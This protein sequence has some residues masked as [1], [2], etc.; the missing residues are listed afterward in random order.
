ML[1]VSD[2]LFAL[3]GFGFGVGCTI[4]VGQLLG[5][6][7]PAQAK[8]AGHSH[9]LP[10]SFLCRLA[11]KAFITT[12]LSVQQ[13][14]TGLS[15]NTQPSVS[16]DLH[17]NFLISPLHPL[18]Y[19]L[20]ADS[21]R[22][23]PPPPSCHLSAP[24]RNM[25]VVQHILFVKDEHSA[26]S[27]FL[28]LVCV[29]YFLSHSSALTYDCVAAATVTVAMGVTAAGIVGLNMFLLSDKLCQAFTRD[30]QVVQ[31]TLLPVQTDFSLA[32]LPSQASA[33]MTF[34]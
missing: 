23:G 8:L 27:G 3:L 30:P 14:C 34:G 31:V 26:Q 16:R 21:S 10:H 4:R 20:D 6:Q 9:L 13:C 1:T 15:A 12:H 2:I 32:T 33:V 19:L 24:H 11:A 29:I 5:A 7:R 17:S 18:S 28:R 25:L 22:T